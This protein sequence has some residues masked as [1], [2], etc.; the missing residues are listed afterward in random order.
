MEEQIYKFIMQG[1]FKTS[2]IEDPDKRVAKNIYKHFMKFL[3]WLD[4]DQIMFTTWD[5]TGERYAT[6]DEDFMP[7][8]YYT[9][10]E[11]YLYWL[12]NINK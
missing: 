2:S 5:E 9:I 3:R 7:V 12:T 8:K 1:Y 10:E 11:V 4:F 6:V